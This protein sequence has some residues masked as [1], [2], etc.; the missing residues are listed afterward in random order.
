MRKTIKERQAK[1]RA[2]QQAQGRKEK[3]FY[4]AEEEHERVKEFIKIIRDNSKNL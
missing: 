4:L 2:E 3:R 1:F